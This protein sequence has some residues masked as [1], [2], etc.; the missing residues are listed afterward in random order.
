MG[1]VF[2]RR[3]TAAL[4][5]LVAA[6]SIVCVALLVLLLAPDWRDTGGQMTS[7]MSGGSQV[8]QAGGTPG[9][10][11]AS[12]PPRQALKPQPVPK[13]TQ[14]PTTTTS[15]TTA[16]TT[17]AL[18]EPWE[19]EYRIPRSTLPHHY[20]LYL[21][22]DLDTGRF[23]GRVG[24]L[25]GVTQPM[26]YLVA[27]IKSMN[28]TKTELQDTSSGKVLPLK[29]YFEYG[30][31]QFWVVQPRSTLA[32]GNYT[33]KLEFE[34]S[35]DGSIVGFYRS[36]YTTKAGE[37]RSIATS[38]FQ[39]TDARSAFPCFD[40]PSFKSTFTTT[41]V[42]PSDGYIALS[43]MPVQ[44]E[45]AES[46][47]AG[48][49]SVVFEK[50]VPMVT[51]LAC[52]IVCDFE[53]VETMTNDNKP[54]RVYATPDQMSRTNYSLHLG[55]HVLNYF[56]DYFEVEYPLPKQ[57]MIAIPDFIS[58]AMEHWG[59][60]TY[61]EVNL[62]YDDL[63]SSSYNKQRV[64]AVVAHE[65]AHM[66][67]GNLVTLDWWDDLWL[68]EGFASYIEYKGVANYEKDWDMEG[69]FLVDDLQLV[70][71]LDAQ[72]TSHPIVQPVNHPD[73]ITEIFD[74]ISY[75][76]GA[77]V[78]RMLES[79]MGSEQFRVGVRNF[80]RKY[81]YANAVTQDLWSELETVSEDGLKISTI[82]D[83]WTRQMGYPV[84]TVTT[85]SADPN[86][87][88][89]KQTRFLSDPEA[90][91][92]DDSP[93]GYV[94]DIP[95]TYITD[96]TQR[97]QRWFYRDMDKLTLTKP[98]GASW[99]KI[100]V[101]QYGYYRV[102]YEASIWQDLVNLLQTNPQALSVT[103]RAS[104]LDDGFNLAGAGLLPYDTALSLVAYMKQETHYIPWTT[105]ASHLAKM[106]RLLRQTNAY[107]Y[108]RKYMVGLVNDHVERLGWNDTGSHLERRNRLVLMFLACSN[109]YDPCLQ[110]AHQRLL[111]W[112][113]D[114]EYYIPPNTRSLVYQF[115][116]QKAGAEE[117]E[118]LLQRYMKEANAQEKTKLAVGLANT[119]EDWITQRLLMLA[120]NESVVRSQDYFS[121]LNNMAKQPWNTHIVWNFVKSNWEEL[122]ERFTLN[123]RYL[124]RMVKYVCTRFTSPDQLMEMKEFFEKY[125]NAGSGARSRQQALEEV[126]G[127]IKWINQ[128]GDSLYDW[129]LKQNNI[130]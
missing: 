121:L 72:L 82:M 90:E 46:P 106:G 57:D 38:K 79:F 45:V 17:E 122:V 47:E 107:P 54:F 20:D 11:V 89:V 13:M 83:S 95:V 115:G 61:R 91:S 67:F 34:G 53:F 128:H 80:L 110:G 75:S 55:V 87:L 43:N 30:P 68:N 40:E 81:K 99:V 119:K 109:G 108:F 112:V 123:N 74:T 65:L 14:R 84:L 6:L 39:P 76:K 120:R 29:D 126:E 16:T 9:R 114:P 8:V 94:W 69:Q 35:L 50:S 125:P 37:K 105:V 19:R 85:S 2:V 97:D 28:M 3:S 118:V 63:G 33:L 23:S 1:Q 73:E 117:W 96:V 32:P 59:L 88:E 21:H 52:F 124:G 18:K 41:L 26:D 31:N 103:D 93:Y 70:M 48:L 22:P 5:F 49:T 78:L 10:V 64:A 77:S 104:L 58:G 51:Y 42:R 60:I 116:M 4:L 56:Q 130:L 92:P 27:H 98:A 71:G 15:T 86:K 101:G 111:S 62:L 7:S 127:N 36:V 113:K 100:N 66:W 44:N 129:F 102:N 25:I 24:I 12:P